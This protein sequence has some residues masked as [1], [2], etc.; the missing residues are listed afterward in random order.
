MK[1]SGKGFTI[2]ELIVVI[3]TIAVLASIVFSNVNKYVGKARDLK[4][5]ADITQLQKALE[6]HYEKYGSYTMPENCDTDNTWTGC[7]NDATGDWGPGSDL[8][9]LVTNG[10]IRSLPKDPINNS[11]YNYLYE[12]GNDG[13]YGLPAGQSYYFC[14]TLEAGGSYCVFKTS[15]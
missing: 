8:R 1:I 12:V 3:A 11:T 7:N 10:F 2:I 15:K 4:R 9:D 6:M 14:A 5:K 13:E